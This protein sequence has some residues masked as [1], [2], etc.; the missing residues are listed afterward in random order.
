MVLK[1]RIK[2]SILRLR[3]FHSLWRLI[4]EDL[5]FNRGGSYDPHLPHHISLLFQGGIRFELC[6]FHSPLLTASQLISSPAPTKM[7]Q[8]R[9]FPIL[10]DQLKKSQEFPLG[11]PRFKGSLCL[12]EAYRNLAR[13]SSALEPSH[14]LNGIITSLTKP[15]GCQSYYVRM[16]TSSGRTQT[17]HHPYLP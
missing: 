4:P 16:I 5:S 3:G 15:I 9:A 8:F 12:P 11:H 10:A 17:S 6:R 13:P 7:F 14:S 2:P 1:L